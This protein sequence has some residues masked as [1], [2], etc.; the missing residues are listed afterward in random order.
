MSTVVFRVDDNLKKE[1]FKIIEGFGLKPNDAL[2][3]FLKQIANTRSLP[4]TFDALPYSPNATTV[5]AI[6]AIENG[7]FEIVD[8]PK[9]ITQALTHDD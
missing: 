7:D 9:D 1:A 5:A 6:E 3:L 8:T 4:I 2:R